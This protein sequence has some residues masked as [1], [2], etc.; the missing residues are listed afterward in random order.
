MSF[1]RAAVIVWAM[2]KR[3]RRPEFQDRREIPNYGIPEA[4]HYLRVAG[5]TLRSWVLGFRPLIRLAQHEP[6]LLSFINLGET[7]VLD[8]IRH[9]HRLPVK[10]VRAA[11][12][13]V[14]REFGSGHPLAQHQFETDGVNLFIQKVDKAALI[15]KDF[16]F[17]FW[18]WA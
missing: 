13:Y 10:T 17:V 7:H 6:P 16:N 4:A 3:A 15:N 18:P 1:R 2:A 5:A 8:A 12:E 14:A 9:Q 11:L